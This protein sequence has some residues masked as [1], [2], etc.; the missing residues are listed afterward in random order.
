MFVVTIAKYTVLKATF[1]V[2][3]EFVNCLP[4]YGNLTALPGA[5]SLMKLHSTTHL[6]RPL[7]IV[8]S[9]QH[10]GDEEKKFEVKSTAL[11]VVTII[12]STYRIFSQASF[13]VPQYWKGLLLPK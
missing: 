12:F 2:A 11:L 7:W 5:V 1:I 10:W 4:P 8:E 6:S 9:A 3:Q 13:N